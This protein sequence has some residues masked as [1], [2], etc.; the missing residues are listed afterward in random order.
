VVILPHSSLAAVVAKRE[1]N[2]LLVNSPQGRTRVLVTDVRPSPWLSNLKPGDLVSIPT[3]EGHP[4]SGSVIEINNHGLV[5]VEAGQ[6][7]YIWEGHI[8]LLTPYE[9][10]EPEPFFFPPHHMNGKQADA[11][12]GAK[13]E[14]ST[15]FKR[16][17][18][19]SGRPKR[20]AP[21]SS[22]VVEEDATLLDLNQ[23][24]DF[25]VQTISSSHA[26]SSE[27]S[28]NTVAA[29]PPQGAPPSAPPS[30]TPT[31]GLT[32]VGSGLPPVRYRRRRLNLTPGGP[33]PIVDAAIVPSTETIPLPSTV[34]NNIQNATH[35]STGAV[36]PQSPPPGVSG[37]Q[38]MNTHTQ[39]QRQQQQQHRQQQRPPTRFMV[40]T[41]VMLPM[42]TGSG[43][44]NAVSRVVP[45]ARN[46][47]NRPASVHS[48]AAQPTS[49]T[50]ALA[51][52]PSPRREPS[53]PPPT[54]SNTQ[55]NNTPSNTT[56]M[57]AH[58]ILSSLSSS[59]CTRVTGAA[60]RAAPTT[61][62]NPPQQNA[63]DTTAIAPASAKASPSAQLRQAYA[64]APLSLASA[65]A[66]ATQAQ[67][68]ALAS[69]SAQNAAL[70]H[71]CV[72]ISNV[73]LIM[74]ENPLT[75][76][77]GDGMNVELNFIMDAASGVSPTSGFGG[78]STPATQPGGLSRDRDHRVRARNTNIRPGPYAHAP[79][80]SAPSAP[81]SMSM[82]RAR[83]LDALRPSAART[84]S[85]H[86]GTR[87][88]ID[89]ET[90]D[91]DDETTRGRRHDT[92]TAGLEAWFADEAVELEA[93]SRRPDGDEDS[94]TWF[95][96]E[97]LSSFHRRRREQGNNDDARTREQG[98][99]A[100]NEGNASVH[101]AGTASVH[102]AGG[103]TMKDEG[104]EVTVS[105]ENEIFSPGDIV[106]VR[107]LKT[108][109]GLR[110]GIGALHVKKEPW[111]SVR[112]KRQDGSYTVHFSG[113]R[114]THFQGCELDKVK[115][116]REGSL[117]RVK[118]T[119][120][121]NFAGKLN[122]HA[123]G[124]LV[125]VSYD[126]Q[127]LV[128]FG[129]FHKDMQLT[130]QSRLWECSLVDLEEDPRSEL[131]PVFI[132]A[133]CPACSGPMGEV[134]KTDMCLTT[135]NFTCGI[136]GEMLASPVTLGCGHSFCRMEIEIWFR[137]NDTCPICRE[138]FPSLGATIKEK[139]IHRRLMH[140][141]G[142]N[143]AL[144]ERKERIILHGVHKMNLNRAIM[145]QLEAQFDKSEI[146]ERELSV[147]SD[148]VITLLKTQNDP[149]T[150]NDRYP[151]SEKIIE[152]FKSFKA[153]SVRGL[154]DSGM[155]DEELLAPAVKKNTLLMY[156]AQAS[157][158]A[159][160]VLI[161]KG[162]Q[163]EIEI[164]DGPHK[165][166]SALSFA[167]SVNKADVVEVLISRMKQTMRYGLT[168]EKFKALV[169]I[170][171]REAL[172][173]GHG[174]LALR[175]RGRLRP[176]DKEMKECERYFAVLACR[177]GDISLLS[178]SIKKFDDHVWERVDGCG[179]H[180]KSVSSCELDSDYGPATYPDFISRQ[181]PLE[182]CT[183][184]PC[185]EYVLE[186]TKNLANLSTSLPFHSAVASSPLAMLPEVVETYV[187]KGFN[188][189]AQDS[190][191]R[192]SVFFLWR[193]GFDDARARLE[194]LLENGI[195]CSICD[196]KNRHPM[197][198]AASKGDIGVFEAL[199]SRSE[200]AWTI[201][202]AGQSPLHIASRCGMKGFVDHLLGYRE[203]AWDLTVECNR[204]DFNGK[205]AYALL[206]TEIRN[207]T[208]GE[209]LRSRTILKNGRDDNDEES[210]PPARRL[211]YDPLS[212]TRFGLTSGSVSQEEPT[213]MDCLMQ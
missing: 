69:R 138:R 161:D 129:D 168:D 60:L 185:I 203:P 179:D 15:R 139:V 147:F 133:R 195:D 22:R 145:A 86:G 202:S 85:E 67:A 35:L 27:S 83:A 166:C 105:P 131:D 213:S 13:T 95:A 181:T 191:G 5:A 140:L 99:N 43:G 155:S 3:Q 141:P 209:S 92:L 114:N 120:V 55:N 28:S 71:Q 8:G 57:N 66:S 89:D 146:F 46:S 136:C 163:V 41:N 123:V 207:T 44:P 12:D 177:R 143:S 160:E 94:E 162:A 2:V 38:I 157:V 158:E 64:A 112:A 153:D 212:Q 154:L 45:R 88:D 26:Q 58:D 23:L 128:D 103:V 150:S 165:G 6:E 197:H 137:S 175:M 106:R 183:T 80:A 210:Q 81:R 117:V 30:T 171:I 90:H 48:S 152:F 59:R 37:S 72:L 77:A 174:E 32:D 115:A 116:P 34:A 118:S 127:C 42:R 70:A 74:R 33:D 200:C 110:Y 20:N 7:G 180:V 76:G 193:A 156:A 1:G 75:G 52:P 178:R 169:P 87:H 100:S 173:A 122:P 194:V 31:Q 211:R 51:I 14:I 102:A 91:I 186:R 109:Q 119:C 208:V 96:N 126:T 9:K 104:G 159:V 206:P 93:S 16:R 61:S 73:P 78:S 205:T 82:A 170:A 25:A 24:Y 111:G 36:L 151:F 125:S 98:N 121:H 4:S 63:H 19:N 50:A 182:A 172:K 134:C 124:K 142:Q 47:S 189:N 11:F 107:F 84:R 108:L 21:S 135:N 49:N 198:L 167:A 40:D 29:T 56:S 188:I 149:Y 190:D 17:V 53:N 164:D 132:R 10:L 62:S 176:K 196:K 97:I 65:S 18:P 130:D 101:A 201:D 184:K 192:T 144:F 199:M 54:P 187:E 148:A 68:R 113:C 79:H 204:R 39:Q